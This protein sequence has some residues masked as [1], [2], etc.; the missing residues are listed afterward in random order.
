MTHA[1]RYKHLSATENFR[2]TSH[3]SCPKETVSKTCL[4]GGLGLVLCSLSSG[5]SFGVG[6]WGGGRLPLGREKQ[7]G[8]WMN[9]VLLSGWG[10]EN[11]RG[12]SRRQYW[13]GMPWPNFVDPE[14]PE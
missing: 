4:V 6:G 5:R 7:Q 12:F 11:P 2:H 1:I 9:P 3:N 8:K 13:K 10:A 14:K